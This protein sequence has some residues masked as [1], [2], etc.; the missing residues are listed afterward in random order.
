MQWMFLA[1]N[2]VFPSLNPTTKE[3]CYN[4]FFCLFVF[5]ETKFELLNKTGV[6]V[7]VTLKRLHFGVKNF[8]NAPLCLRYV[9]I[10]IVYIFLK[11]KKEKIC[12]WDVLIHG[13]WPKKETFLI[14]SLNC[15]SV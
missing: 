13:C 2:S 4:I 12:A 1:L 10:T 5:T 11:K 8:Q 9:W 3:T 7:S 6:S 14:G 15:K